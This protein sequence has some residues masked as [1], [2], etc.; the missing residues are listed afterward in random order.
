MKFKNNNFARDQKLHDLL[1]I[2]NEK[3][4]KKED[5]QS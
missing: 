1:K 3:Y 4:R 2:Y 5:K